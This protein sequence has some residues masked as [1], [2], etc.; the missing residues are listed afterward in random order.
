[1]ER[2]ISG[3]PSECIDTLESAGDPVFFNTWQI[4]SIDKVILTHRIRGDFD[5]GDLNHRE[6]WQLGERCSG[7]RH[8]STETG[9][10]LY[11]CHCPYE[12][13]YRIGVGVTVP[14]RKNPIAFKMLKVSLKSVIFTRTYVA[15][16]PRL[17]HKKLCSNHCSNAFI[18]A[19]WIKWQTRDT[20]ASLQAESTCLGQWWI[21]PFYVNIKVF[22]IQRLL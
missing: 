6:V 18:W 14:T 8:S 3:Y 13:R 5:N 15:R 21:K 12:L 2:G 17:V 9:I 20:T 22:L 10:A 7:L 11:I 19:P 1:M 16:V 4:F